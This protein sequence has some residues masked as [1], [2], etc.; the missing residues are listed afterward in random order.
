MLYTPT[1]FN[2]IM[3]GLRMT[4]WGRMIIRPYFLIELFW[5]YTDRDVCVTFL[6]LV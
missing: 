5:C 2:R 1:R 4:Q 3:L 6:A